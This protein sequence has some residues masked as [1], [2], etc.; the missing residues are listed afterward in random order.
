MLKRQ[1]KKINKYI[2]FLMRKEREKG[3]ISQTSLLS[4][5]VIRSGGKKDKAMADV[6]AQVSSV[7]HVLGT[8]PTRLS[9]MPHT[10]HV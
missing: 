10:L 3:I 5:L 6:L 7:W 8:P 2:K 4:T 9:R 1:V